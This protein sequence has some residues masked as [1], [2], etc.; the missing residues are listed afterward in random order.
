M[1]AINHAVAALPLKRRYPDVSLPLLLI[2]VQ[3]VE[4]LWVVLNL[5]GIEHT[6]TEASVRYVGDIH[7]D[8]MPWSHSLLGVAAIAMSAWLAL[9]LSGR[10]RA[11]NAVGLGVISHVVL[12]L[13]THSADIALA[14]YLDGPKLGLGLYATTPLLAFGLEL[15]FAL[16]CWRIY[17]GSP[18]L[19]A[20]IV[21]FNL[22]NLTMFV[23]SI[24]G[25]EA[26]MAGQPLLITLVIGAQIAVTLLVVGLLAGPA[27]KEH[28]AGRLGVRPLRNAAGS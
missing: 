9:R 10:G 18:R 28:P 2:S 6:H 5:L 22:A 26:H 13:I 24:A 16:A 3:A 27:E 21:L 11:A 8:A 7:L 14:P 20:A 23:P 15:G 4:L 17:R 19:L 1:F 12:D 25:L